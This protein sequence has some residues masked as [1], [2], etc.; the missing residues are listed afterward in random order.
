[1]RSCT[2]GDPWACHSRHRGPGLGFGHGAK[3]PGAA[4]SVPLQGRP[5][6][7]GAVKPSPRGFRGSPFQEREDR[8][9]FCGNGPCGMR[10]LAPSRLGLEAP[11]GHCPSSTRWALRGAVARGVQTSSG[12]P[13]RPARRL[14]DHPLNLYDL[15]IRYQP[16]FFSG[17]F[18][19]T[20]RRRTP[21]ALATRVTVSGH[22]PCA[23]AD[24]ARSARTRFPVIR[25]WH[26]ARTLTR[27]D[28]DRLNG[29][30]KAEK[31]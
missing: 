30:E 19:L 20:A 26:G 25:A 5:R 29:A 12:L 17:R 14:V 22:R 1:M 9:A 18:R 7:S 27:Q 11:E 13:R 10:P 24:S 15:F 21:V 3:I 4:S 28:V 23:H 2:S 31:S 8:A 16:F 6:S